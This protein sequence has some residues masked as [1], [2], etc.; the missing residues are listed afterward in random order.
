MM[1]NM[2]TSKIA[3][4]YSYEDQQSMGSFSLGEIPQTYTYNGDTMNVTETI[5]SVLDNYS[6]PISIKNKLSNELGKAISVNKRKVTLKE[7][8][9]NRKYLTT[10]QVASIVKNGNIY[11]SCVKDEILKFIPDSLRKK[12]L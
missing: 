12:K 5:A 1:M 7:R 2:K 4:S 6:I 10:T 8:L 9:V 11:V 3:M